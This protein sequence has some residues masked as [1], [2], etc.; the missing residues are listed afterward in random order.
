MQS[1]Q[2][3]GRYCEGDP[4]KLRRKL[5]DLFETIDTPLEQRDEYMDE[6]LAAFP[7]VNGGLFAD[8]SII[9]PQMTSEILEAIADVRTL[10]GARSRASSSAACSRAR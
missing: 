5:V 4:A 10:T 3:F 6:D 8:S 7:Y 9:V 2:A 1:H